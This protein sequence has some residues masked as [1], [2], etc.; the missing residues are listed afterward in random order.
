MIVASPFNQNKSRTIYI[1][2]AKLFGVRRAAV[3]K[4]IAGV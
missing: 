3:G 1:A 4:L 2:V